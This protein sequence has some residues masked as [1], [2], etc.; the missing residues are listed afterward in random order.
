MNVLSDFLAYVEQEVLTIVSNKDN[1]A[2]VQ[3]LQA[4]R[5]AHTRAEI[6]AIDKDLPL[7][8]LK[9]ALLES[10]GHP[11]LN[12][13]Y[14]KYGKKG[15]LE[16]IPYDELI[17]HLNNKITEVLS[18]E[19]FNIDANAQNASKHRADKASLEI[20]NAN[21][22]AQFKKQD[23]IPNT[24]EHWLP[25]FNAIGI[26]TTLLKT[27]VTQLNSIQFAQL[28][29]ACKHYRQARMFTSHWHTPI[30]S[31]PWQLILLSQD[32]QAIQQL[33][34]DP[35]VPKRDYLGRHY[36]HYFLIAADLTQVSSVLASDSAL[37]DVQ[38][39]FGKNALH[40]AALSGNPAAMEFLLKKGPTLLQSRDLGGR[41]ALHYAAW[42]G[43]PEAIDFLLM[44]DS[45]LLQ[46]KDNDG[47]N[48]LHY[49]AWSG[50]PAAIDFL[51]TKDPAL[52]QSKDNNG[53][54]ALHY[55]ALS[56][57]PDAMEFLLKKD[58]T[59]LQ[60][61]DNNGRNALHYAALSGNPDAMEFLLK[62]DSKLLQSKA[63]DGRNTLHYAA[64]SGNPDAMSYLIRKYPKQSACL[65]VMDNYGNTP[66]SF[67]HKSKCPI[68][69][70]KVLQAVL[71]DAANSIITGKKHEIQKA[72]MILD[73]Y[74]DKF[75]AMLD[76]EGMFSDSE[77]EKITSNKYITSRLGKKFKG[78]A[79][80]IAKQR[81]LCDKP[82][83]YRELKDIVSLASQSL[84]AQQNKFFKDPSLLVNLKTL[85]S[86]SLSDENDAL[87]DDMLT[88][89]MLMID[90]HQR[91]K[92]NPT[93]RQVD[94]AMIRAIEATQTVQLLKPQVKVTQGND[95]KPNNF[96]EHLKKC[97]DK[98]KALGNISAD[99]RRITGKV[100]KGIEH[101]ATHHDEIIQH[102]TNHYGKLYYVADDLPIHTD[103]VDITQPK[104]FYK[105]LEHLI[106]N[107]F[108][109]FYLAEKA[110]QLKTFCDKVSSG[111]CF[112][113]K[114]RE[115]FEW[116]SQLSEIK[117]FHTLM[118]DYIKEYLAYYKIMHGQSEKNSGFVKKAT[119]FICQRH[120][121]FYCQPD[122]TYAPNG[123]VTRKGVAVYLEE[124][125]Y[126]EQ[127]SLM[128]MVKSFL[129]KA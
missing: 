17:E 60:S 129:G 29:T 23:K 31:T 57:N 11:L 70:S 109:A 5:S 116:A 19:Q 48:A 107:F 93:T 21:A 101:I 117:P 58:P 124:I 69:A 83:T 75:I 56:G 115:P 122:K 90:D 74:A 6:E 52:L 25:Q 64:W 110:G 14:D 105:T 66:D 41:N 119:D 77:L 33:I 98:L 2:G 79:S 20:S 82:L 4:L 84:P 24:L 126:F 102:V 118:G 67:A 59:L 3:A 15:N 26:S 99:T 128:R 62:K 104:Q 76:Q 108:G 7:G 73:A 50:N 72:L 85:L 37:I 9:S 54:N 36:L 18:K 112:E 22:G 127:Q 123:Q 46:S 30:I 78:I 121:D 80:L 40:Y 28:Y 27:T 96:D 49:A 38:D 89:L 68:S 45:T 92:L 32:K 42:S 86:K 65:W 61:K 95:I 13:L 8:K 1:K 55:A 35:K 87:S 114:V 47:T 63:K 106:E 125:L 10:K 81:Q 51:L 113:G 53:R 120:Q 34:K 12:D 111:Y 88:V 44:K 71:K 16:L 91:G 39:N 43:N 100:L 103:H 94:N 97:R